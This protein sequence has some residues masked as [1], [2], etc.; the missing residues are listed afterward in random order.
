MLDLC[1]GSGDIAFLLSQKVGLDGEVGNIQ[2]SGLSSNFLLLNV[3]SFRDS[4]D[5][6][7]GCRFFEAAAVYCC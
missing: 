1:C 7:D 4:N 3:R 6:G 5:T 2:T